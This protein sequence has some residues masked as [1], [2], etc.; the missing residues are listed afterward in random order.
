MRK[1]LLL[2]AFV[3]AALCQPLVGAETT[4]RSGFDSRQIR[5]ERL[6]H[7]IK[8]SGKWLFTREDNPGNKAM[9]LDT[10]KWVM[11][12]APG[13]WKHAY[14]DH[15]NFTVGWYRGM[16]EFNPALVGQEAVLLVDAYMG[17]I[18]VYLDGTEIYERPE[19]INVERYYSIQP[20]PVR[21]KI[22]QPRQVIAIRVET[23][24]MT[25]IYELPFELHR[26]NQ[27]D[28]TLAFH[29]FRGGESRMIVAYIVLFFGLFFLLVY[30]KTRYSLYLV[31]ALYSL[32]AF[33]FYA[34]PGDIF[35]KV[36]APETMLYLHYTGMFSAFLA[37]LFSQYYFKFTPKI[38]WIFGT[39]FGLIGLRIGAM[40]WAPNVDLFQHLRSV[41][42]LMVLISGIAATYM[43]VRAALNG[44]THSRILLTGTVL[45]LASGIN[46][47]LLALGH[48]QSFGMMFA[49]NA[50]FTGS[51]LYVACLTFANTFQENRQLVKELKQINDRLEDLVAERTQQLRQKTNDIST[52]LQNMP[53]GIL[54]IMAGGTIHPEYSAYLETIF[55]TDDIA[56]RDMMDLVFSDTDLGPDVLAQVAAV[57]GV[58]IGE[59]RMNFEFNT[60]VMVKEFQ[61]HMPDGRLKALELTWSPICDEQDTI[62]KLMLCVRDTTLLKR[63][64]AEA[65]QQKRELEIIGQ[66]L[67]VSQEKFHEF[68]ASSNR[69]VQ[70]NAAV[71]R[72]TF[73]KHPEII[74]TLFRNMHTIKGNART[75]GLLHLTNKV[76]E[77]E[78]AYDDLRKNPEAL[79]NQDFLLQQLDETHSLIAEYEK[80]NDSKLGRKGPGRRGGVE[81]FLM[82]EKDSIQRSLDLI[83]QTD[84]NDIE[85]LRHTLAQTA[86]ALNLIGTEKIADI[87]GG[88]IESMPS[89]ASELGKAA[90]VI[91]LEDHG[92]VVRNQVSGLLKNMATHLFRN[93]IDHGIE[94]AEARQAQGKS[95]EGHIHLACSLEGGRFWLK[96]R[97][98]GKGLAIERIRQIGLAKGLLGKDETPTPEAI[99]ELIFISGFSTAEQVTEVSG[100]GVGMDAIK[101]FLEREAGAIQIQFLDDNVQAEFR[102]FQIVISLPDKFA[103]QADS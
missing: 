21:F 48:I 18:A 77:A 44:K 14:P 19:N 60:H 89:L 2:L 83:E 39:I 62:E 70:E 81:K 52:M 84:P 99:A 86:K 67:S 57:P 28:T 79:W 69:F 80:I 75:Y 27:H 22:T 47:L 4:V 66:V 10:T 8:L 82:V 54:T 53:Q 94:S 40:A 68:I 25:G 90:P 93:S 59:D 30:S 23:P 29:Q 9:E 11:I 49:G 91:T 51:I 38:N 16:F 45:F 33:P 26:Y 78:Q 50:I 101:G 46:D 5:V 55:E 17:R 88:V 97:D 58:C 32:A 35:L 43:L 96:M 100:R 7:P 6:D 74:S 41:Y 20:A 42:F 92:I 73:E 64:E 71:I 98:D 63:L 65:T 15:K 72:K 34:A 95:P 37:Y 102:P 85:A 1:A 12:N 31:A 24:L 13:P 87:L 103:V 61:K 76:H 56:G 3:C 36:F